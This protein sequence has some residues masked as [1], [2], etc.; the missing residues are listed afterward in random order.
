[1]VI[2]FIRKPHLWGFRD[3]LCCFDAFQFIAYY[4]GVCYLFGPLFVGTNAS[5]IWV[6]AIL[7]PFAI[8]PCFWL[9]ERLLDRRAREG[10]GTLPDCIL[11]SFKIAGRAAQMQRVLARQLPRKPDGW[12]FRTGLTSAQ[13]AALLAVVLVVLPGMRLLECSPVTLSL[14]CLGADV[15]LL[16]QYAFERHAYIVRGGS[17]IVERRNR[18][19]V[20][21]SRVIPLSAAAVEADLAE[22]ILRIRTTEETMSIDLRSILN[23]HG[24][25][26]AVLSARIETEVELGAV[27][28][29]V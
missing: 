15:T 16:L 23:P 20:T 13:H 29:C 7:A 18:L 3:P 8:G 14:V 17:L 25:L 12:R 28:A 22:G 2:E 19:I 27:E 1:M 6:M 5:G 24:L 26:S 9:R 4:G 21:A 11:A 10:P